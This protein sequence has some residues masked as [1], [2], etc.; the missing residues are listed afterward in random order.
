[1]LNVIDLIIVIVFMLAMLY[2]GFRSSK[3]IHTSRDYVVAGGGLSFGVTLATMVATGMGAGNLFGRSGYAYNAGAAMTMAMV[4]SLAANI[5]V[6]IFSMKIEKYKGVI[7]LPQLFSRF[8]GK[9][10]T[11]YYTR[12]AAGGITTLYNA[13]LLGT[14]FV[15]FGTLFTLLG[16]PLG[17]TPQLAMAF[18]ALVTIV[19]TGVGGMHSV[20]YTDVVQFVVM[21]VGIVII[22]PIV[23]VNAAGGYSVIL[24][25]A[26]AAGISAFNPFSARSPQEIA[27]LFLV[28]WFLN[29]VDPYIWQRV[30]SAKSFKIARRAAI[31]NSIICFF[32]CLALVQMALAGRVLLPDIVATHGTTEAIL[33]TLILTAFP[34]GIIGIMLSGCLATLMST[35]DSYLLQASLSLVKDVVVFL[36]PEMSEEKQVRLLKISTI[37]MG[38]FGLVVA[39]FAK[40]V[41]SA[42]SFSFSVYGAA[43]FVP[44]LCGLYWKKTTA[45]GALV[46]MLVGALVVIYG[47]F[48]NWYPG[49][50]DPVLPGIIAAI[51]CL[52]I[53]SLLTQKQGIVRQPEEAEVYAE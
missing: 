18:G 8:W 36:K 16:S 23:A 24:E 3:K 29:S 20:A 42:L 2:I 32:F 53:V 21:M 17:V 4:G 25:N 13:L 27:S 35:A 47:F 11:A 40:G 26:A 46:S 39:L 33:P 43:L 10:G 22:G 34:T 12:L 6:A 51:V 28:G 45:A 41:F 37:V 31:I 1:M 19:Y 49:G 44:T 52:V 50:W 38:L 48:A 14:Q 5:T 7:T 9:T 30:F 15:A